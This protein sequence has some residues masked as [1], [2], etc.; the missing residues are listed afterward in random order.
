M[1]TIGKAAPPGSC[2]G[3][4][5]DDSEAVCSHPKAGT[6]DGVGC[7]A[8]SIIFVEDTAHR[9]RFLRRAILSSDSGSNE[10]VEYLGK[11]NPEP[12]TNDEI[13]KA[14]DDA[15]ILA[16]KDGYKWDV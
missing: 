1:R 15:I 10:L 2:K 6:K 14:I 3:C 9:Y 11:A 7:S 16:E 13:D 4:I 5:H 12:T 8:S